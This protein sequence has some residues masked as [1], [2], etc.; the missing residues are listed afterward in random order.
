MF[1]LFNNKHSCQEG[2]VRMY[3]QGQDVRETPEEFDHTFCGQSLPQSVL[4]DGPSLSMVFSSGTT[5]GQGFKA[6]Y[7]FETDYKIP[8]TPVPGGCHFIYNSASGTKAGD[9][10]SPRYPTNYP[11]NTHC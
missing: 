11:S 4:S 9:I 8:G 5:Q 2:Y 6:R 1:I 3:I 7:T 10:Q